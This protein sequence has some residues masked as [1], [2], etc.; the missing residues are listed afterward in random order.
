MAPIRRG[1]TCTWVHTVVLNK[2]RQFQEL[3]HHVLFLIGDFT[4]LIGDPSG[5]NEARPPL[6]PEAIGQNAAT[7]AEQVFKI[8][9]PDQTEVV[10]N[11]HWISKLT[12][13]DFIRL[14]SQ[15]TVARMIERDDFTKR[16]Q[17]QTPIYLHEFIYP[18]VQGYDSVALKSDVELGGTD[19]KFNLLV[20]RDLQ[21]AAGQEPQCIMTMPLLEGLD[22][23]Q[24][25]SKSLDNY[26]GVEDSPRDMFGKVMRVSDTLMLRW[27]DL[28]SAQT[29]EQLTRLRADLASGAV[30][31]R[32]AKVALAREITARFHGAEAGDRAVAEFDRIFVDKGLPDEI[33]VHAISAAATVGILKMMVEVGLATSNGE[34]KRLIEGPRG[35]DGRRQDHRSAT[36]ARP[37][38]RSEFCVEGGQEKIRPRDGERMKVKF[39]PQNLEFEIKPGQSVMALAHEKGIAIRSTCNGMPSCA[40]CRVNITDGDYNVNPPSRKELSLI[41]TGY[42]IDQR[43]LSCQVLC[44]GDITVDTQEQIEKSAEGPVTKKFL[45]RVHK[46]SASESHSLGGVMLEQDGQ[47]LASLSGD[48]PDAP[49]PMVAA[50]LSEKSPRGG[51][52]GGRSRGGGGGGG[53]T[54]GGRG[55]GGSP[56]AQPTGD[57]QGG[58]PKGEGGGRR[59]RRRGG[60]GR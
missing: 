23:V 27:Y 4:A 51:G 38:G 28:L 37:H 26:V 8:L 13:A 17:A 29:L 44:F 60:R 14:T 15:Y 33:P 53:G 54:Q 21:K 3:G 50:S 46:S 42:Y 7:Y 56:K 47:L 41:G 35:R 9:D 55:G 48:V 32:A 49:A 6:S 40:E 43:R 39:M 45:T 19:Q 2:L 16:Y 30:H 24:K 12:P 57:G 52:G 11:S 1:P 31:P 5:R 58:G 10:Y 59:R 34:A 18:L 25:M 36:E 22:G 20:G